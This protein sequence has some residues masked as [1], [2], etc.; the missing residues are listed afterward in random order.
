MGEAFRQVD[1]I[2]AE[3]AGQL[4][5]RADQQR[6]AA[7]AGDLGEAAAAGV[8]VSGPERAVDDGRALRQALGDPL[9]IRRPLRVGEEQ[10]RRQALPST[11]PPA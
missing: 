3:A 6:E 7:A 11:V 4:R 9:G 8:G 2:G 1:A 5:V 10:Q